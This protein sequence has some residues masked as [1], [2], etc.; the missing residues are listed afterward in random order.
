M[1]TKIYLPRL[2]E[3]IE[4]ATIGCYMKKVGQSVQRGDVIA[5]LE[6]AKAMIELESPV[7]GILLAVFP[8]EGETIKSGTLVAIV[9]KADEDWQSELD[10][11]KDKKEKQNTKRA[12]QGQQQTNKQK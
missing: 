8:E 9:G 1:A 2:G 12:K 4:E 6:T 5:E 11:K 7:K 10:E 3:S